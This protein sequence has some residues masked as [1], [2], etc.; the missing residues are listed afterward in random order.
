M[1]FIIA[2]NFTKNLE[3]DYEKFNLAGWRARRIW[4][5]Q[6]DYGSPWRYDPGVFTAPPNPLRLSLAWHLPRHLGR[7]AA[8]FASSEPI[9]VAKARDLNHKLL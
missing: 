3:K 7:G 2:F 9:L 1:L 5:F 6:A 4:L 8:R